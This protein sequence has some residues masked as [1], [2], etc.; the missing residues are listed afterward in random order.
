MKKKSFKTYIIIPFSLL[1]LNAVEEVAMYKLNVIIP[2]ENVHFKVIASIVLF[3]V[4]LSILA[5]LI[6]PHIESMMEGTHKVSKGQA[7]NLG[8]TVMVVLASLCIVY[9]IYYYIYGL[10]APEMLLPLEWR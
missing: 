2:P 3:S 5:G 7:G 10:N 1:F 9:Y 8:G 6:I 4:A